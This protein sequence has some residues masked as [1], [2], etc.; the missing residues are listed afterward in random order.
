MSS[1]TAPEPRRRRP[2][3]L[4]AR[5]AAWYAG[6]A[7]LLVLLAT[8]F[9]YWV[10]ATNLDREDDDLLVDKVQVVRMLLREAPEVSPALR[11]EVE[12]ESAARQNVRFYIRILGPD[13][14]RAHRVADV[15]EPP[16]DMRSP[17]VHERVAVGGFPAELFRLAST[18]NERFDRLEESFTRLARF[19]ADIAHELRTPVNVLRGEAEVALGKPR[20]SDEY[21]EVLGSCLEECGRLA[22]LID[23]LL[24][25]A[26]AENPETQIAKE[27]VD[28]GRELAIV[29]DFYEAAAADSGV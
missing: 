17:T 13:G 5:L 15:G 14:R 19:S 4:A 1:K 24:F 7:F 6:T 8:G 3:P 20:S 12:W 2:W 26:R 10:L 9:W 27:R 23:S 22:H 28:V 18:F 21:R 11:Q 25:L 29:R 16:G